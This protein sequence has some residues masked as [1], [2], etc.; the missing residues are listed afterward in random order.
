[1]VL[2]GRREEKMNINEYLAHEREKISKYINPKY[3][4]NEAIQESISPTKRFNLQTVFY[5]DKGILP[6]G[7]P[8]HYEFMTCNIF[9]SDKKYLQ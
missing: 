5:A 4:A 9:K 7:V 6:N 3:K 2:S 8:S 1:M